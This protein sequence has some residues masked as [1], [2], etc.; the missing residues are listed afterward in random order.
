M[1]GRTSRTSNDAPQVN[2]VFTL[3]QSG[4]NATIAATVTKSRREEEVR[5]RSFMIGASTTRFRMLE[6]R[7]DR[8]THVVADRR[9]IRPTATGRL[10]MPA[11][12]V[13]PAK[14]RRQ[15]VTRVFHRV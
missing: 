15:C 9:Q 5:A 11:G 12:A 14:T 3:G 6:P 4:P 8:V 1:S 2:S 13:E 10:A 7:A